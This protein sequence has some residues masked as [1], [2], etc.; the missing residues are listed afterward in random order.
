MASAPRAA[1]EE[2]ADRFIKALGIK[3]PKAEQAVAKLSGGNSAKSAVG[4]LAGER[5]AIAYPG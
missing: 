4:P 1:Q 3:T 2:I 5:A